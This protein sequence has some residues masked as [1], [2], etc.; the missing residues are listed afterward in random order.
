MAKVE[1]EIA[2]G[3]IAEVEDRLNNVREHPDTETMNILGYQVVA[4]P[5]EEPGPDRYRHFVLYRR[6]VDDQQ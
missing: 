4:K 2:D 5:D 1:H 6:V 3:S